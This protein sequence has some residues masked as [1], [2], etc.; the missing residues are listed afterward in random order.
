MS[1]FSNDEENAIR[2][3]VKLERREIEL[4]VR[5]RVRIEV[6]ERRNIRERESFRKMMIFCGIVLLFLLLVAIGSHS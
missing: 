2:E 3:R 6:E 1:I 4:S 5:E